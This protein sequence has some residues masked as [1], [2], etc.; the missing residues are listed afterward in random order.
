MI[1]DTSQKL[2]LA[3]IRKEANLIEPDTGQDECAIA[4]L[5]FDLTL[6]Q[7]QCLNDP[8]KELFDGLFAIVIQVVLPRATFLRQ[9]L[10]G[11]DPSVG[12]L[13]KIVEEAAAE[14]FVPEQHV[15]S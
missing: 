9:L 13:I 2:A 15:C 5:A 8:L 4:T 10:R 11:E 12:L 14:S 3:V 1:F 7:T 6:L